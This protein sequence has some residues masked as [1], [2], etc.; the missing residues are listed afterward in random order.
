MSDASSDASHSKAF[1]FL[2]ALRPL[3]ACPDARRLI[4]HEA[5]LRQNARATE[6]ALPCSFITRRSPSPDCPGKLH[7]SEC[8]IH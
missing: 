5:P 6:I 4:P 8:R 2:I 1:R 3:A 7:S